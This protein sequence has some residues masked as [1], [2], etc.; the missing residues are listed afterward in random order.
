MIFLKFKCYHTS[1]Q[2]LHRFAIDCYQIFRH[3]WSDGQ[4]LVSVISQPSLTYHLA[5]VSRLLS[6]I[7]TPGVRPADFTCTLSSASV[8]SPLLL[9]T[10]KTPA[11]SSFKSQINT[12]SSAKIFL[13]FSSYSQ[14]NPHVLP[15]GSHIPVHI[16]VTAPVTRQYTVPCIS[17]FPY[18]TEH[19]TICIIDGG[20]NR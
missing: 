10:W 11:F 14:S 12:A 20:Y 17:A 6:F 18:Q 4:V 9:S 3:R 5:A 2:T 1:L 7:Y 16:S 15:F 13:C 8:S 19:H